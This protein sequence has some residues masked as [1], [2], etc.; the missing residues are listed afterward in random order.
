MAYPKMTIFDDEQI[1]KMKNMASVRSYKLN[2]LFNNQILN[3]CPSYPKYHAS[4]GEPIT[5]LP[6]FEE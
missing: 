2:G 3:T 1:E 4:H 5:K 6:Q